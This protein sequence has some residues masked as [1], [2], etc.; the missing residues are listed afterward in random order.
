VAKAG[1]ICG[2]GICDFTGSFAHMHA[3]IAMEIDG[4]LFRGPR[5]LG[6]VHEKGSKEHEVPSHH[7]LEHQWSKPDGR[8]RW[9]QGKEASDLNR[10]SRKS[11][12]PWTSLG[13]I[14][15][16]CMICG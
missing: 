1:T 5:G 3:V 11:S 13:A 4:I 15:M 16:V 9:R 14:R 6:R 8:V 10:K 7:T 2:V 12:P